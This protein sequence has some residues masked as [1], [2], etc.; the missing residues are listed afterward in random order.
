MS[1]Q[2][3]EVPSKIYVQVKDGKTIT[4]NRVFDDDICYIRKNALLEWVEC[5]LS[6][7]RDTRDDY[8]IPAIVVLND[9]IDKLNSM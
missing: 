6:K 7:R 9:L 2:A 5:E 1:K 4:L 3:E 8:F